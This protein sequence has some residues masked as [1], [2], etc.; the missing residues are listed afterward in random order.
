MAKSIKASL[1]HVAST[2]N[3][4]QHHTCSDGEDSWCGHKRDSTTYKQRDGIPECI[5][6]LI[7]PIFKDLSDPNLLNKCTHGL[8]QNVNECLNGLIWDQYPKPTSVEW[9]TVAL[10]TYLAVLKF[11]DGD[12]SFTKIFDEQGMK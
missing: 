8:T 12:I 10:A 4:P 6:T 1:H 2:D 3:N 9:E 5:V 7:E 11:N